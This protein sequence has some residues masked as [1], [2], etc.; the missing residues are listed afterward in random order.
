MSPQ[1]DV[2]NLLKCIDGAEKYHRSGRRKYRKVR[3]VR[4]AV[5]EKQ[6]PRYVF[7]VV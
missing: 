7:A 1:G 2:S 5:K 6:K 3:K 4:K